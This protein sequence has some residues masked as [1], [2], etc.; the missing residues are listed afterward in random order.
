MKAVHSFLGRYQLPCRY[1]YRKI[2]NK[3]DFP[4]F[5]V[6]SVVPTH[7]RVIDI[8]ANI[9]I[10]SYYF[11]KH[12]EIV[13]AFEPQLDCAY[14]IFQCAS[15]LSN[16]KIHCTALSEK[17]DVLPLYIPTDCAGKIS[18][19]AT[20]SRNNRFDQGKC[21]QV[22]TCR[23]DDYKF[24]DVS[25]I[26]IDVEGYEHYVL[27][28]AEKTIKENKPFLLMEIEQR[29]IGEKPIYEIFREVL[30]FGYRGFFFVGKR[31]LPIR[32]F[33]YEV[34]QKPFIENISLSQIRAAL[35]IDY[36]NNFVFEPI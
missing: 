30:D 17:N 3:L 24:K 34:H 10:Y 12:F 7:K 15:G 29:H 6:N 16:V 5:Y 31:K 36:A 9:G 26:K 21:V 20:L 35:P 8:G 28:G 2:F 18:E 11:S 27:R 23:L 13:E 19:L 22:P 33:V 25:L 1:Y 14:A 32:E 4:M